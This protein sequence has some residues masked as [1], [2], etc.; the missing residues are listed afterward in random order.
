M[1]AQ[2]LIYSLNNYLT[3]QLCNYIYTGG[4]PKGVEHRYLMSSENCTAWSA[5]WEFSTLYNWLAVNCTA[6]I[7]LL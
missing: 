5:D 7:Q 2:S 3:N 1:L 6:S 4:C